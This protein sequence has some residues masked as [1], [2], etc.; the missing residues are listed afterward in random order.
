MSLKKEK[1]PIVGKKILIEQIVKRNLDIGINKMQIETILDSLELEIID[2]V[3]SGKKIKMGKI[4]Y[5][6]KKKSKPREAMNLK[7]GEKM[8]IGER[9]IVSFKTL[10][11]FKEK[12]N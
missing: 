4:F 2:I 5:I 6:W 1:L 10:P 3:N 8:K 12:I 9:W 11:S 7:T